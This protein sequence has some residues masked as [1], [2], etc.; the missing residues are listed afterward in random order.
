[1]DKRAGKQH[2]D[3]FR[4]RYRWY[5]QPHQRKGSLV[6]SRRALKSRV[7]PTK[8]HRHR[9]R[10]WHL[11]RHRHLHQHLHQQYRI[12]AIH[13]LVKHRNPRE[14]RSRQLLTATQNPLA[15][16]PPWS[17]QRRPL[18][19]PQ[20][21][22]Q[23]QR[24][25]H[26]RAALCLRYPPP[27]HPSRHQEQDPVRKLRLL[28]LRFL[29]KH[30]HLHLP[31]LI[32]LRALR[33]RLPR[34]PQSSQNERNRACRS[35]GVKMPLRGV[36]SLLRESRGPRPRRRKV[37]RPGLPRQRPQPEPPAQR[38]ALLQP[39]VILHGKPRLP[40][41]KAILRQPSTK[42]TS[43]SISGNQHL[44]P[45]PQLRRHLLLP[46]SLQVCS[47]HLRGVRDTDSSKSRMHLPTSNR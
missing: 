3:Q 44:R 27:Y 28:L 17:L 35:P 37:R 41:D 43:P 1:M 12:Q 45:W 36:H 6:Q 26:K 13:Q 15:L 8:R 7:V 5:H 47:S 38:R 30:V 42:L 34:H 4:R 14:I 33:Q 2:Q 24:Q 31:N 32:L 25:N 19:Q 29:P 23:P 18:Q 40:R 10:H 21:R 22:H 9:H 16:L 39:C 11:H 20:Q 46:Q